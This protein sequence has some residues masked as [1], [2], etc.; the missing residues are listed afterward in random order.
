MLAI[1]ISIN[2]SAPIVVAADDYLLATLSYGVN[3]KQKSD[4]ILA[5]GADDTYSYRWIDQ[6]PQEGDKV[7]IR[8]V[9]VSRDKLTIP[10]RIIKRDREKMKQEYERLKQELQSKRLL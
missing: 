7:L 5:F 8:V 10:K 9:D 2:N 3:A 1:E 4:Y 6:I